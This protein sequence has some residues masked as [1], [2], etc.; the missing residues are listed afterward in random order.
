MQKKFLTLAVASAFAL[1]S[2]GMAFAQVSP[3]LATTGDKLLGAIY[4]TQA[5]NETYLSITNTTNRAK[6]VKF[7]MREGRGSEDSLDFH[8]YLSPYDMWTAALTENSAGNVVLV[9]QDTSCTV[10]Q[11][12]GDPETSRAIA[13]TNYIPSIYEDGSAEAAAARVAE[14]YVE[15]I[16]MA[17]FGTAPASIDDDYA[18]RAGTEN[19]QAQDI[20]WA[21]KHVDGVPRDCA[22]VRDFNRNNIT[23]VEAARNDFGVPRGGLFGNMAVI[24]VAQG[25]FLTFEMDV[26]N[27]GFDTG[28]DGDGNGNIFFSQNPNEGPGN[29]LT[30]YTADRGLV[31]EKV[32]LA[33]G[34]NDLVYFDLPSLSTITSASGLPAATVTYNSVAAGESATL[35]DVAELLAPISALLAVPSVTNEY[36]VNPLAG[37]ATDWVITFPTKRYHTNYAYDEETGAPLPAAASGAL[38]AEDG[39]IA[40]FREGFNQARGQACERIRFDQLRDREETRTTAPVGEIEFSPGRPDVVDPS[41][42]CFEMNVVSFNDSDIENPSKVVGGFN[43]RQNLPV[44]F[45][46]G[47]ATIVFDDDLPVIGFMAHNLVNEAVSEGVLANYAGTFGHRYIG[48]R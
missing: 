42:L 46:E 37:A 2:A 19:M 43:T 36:I 31:F 45:N 38:N 12:T 21:T 17:D 26:I 33:D 41:T 25:T 4:N 6:A 32:F 18:T 34:L 7:R 47:W 24:N 44:P 22:S 48:G 28:L 20:A 13:G 16:E 11:V 1:G 8:V 9:T 29:V 30:T 27:S 23:P 10:P 40:P 35:T 5:G 14:G 15:I 39:W 3:S